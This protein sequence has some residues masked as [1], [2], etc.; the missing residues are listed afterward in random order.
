MQEGMGWDVV[1]C[2]HL[3]LCKFDEP[4]SAP[5]DSPKPMHACTVS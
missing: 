5:V 3:C 2:S 4:V 1:C